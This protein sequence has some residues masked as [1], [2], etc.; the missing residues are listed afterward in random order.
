MHAQRTKRSFSK[1]QSLPETPSP[2]W[3]RPFHTNQGKDLDRKPAAR[4]DTNTRLNGAE[5]RGHHLGTFSILNQAPLAVQPRL[6]VRPAGDRYEQEA[7]RIAQQVLEMPAENAHQHNLGNGETL[8]MESTSQR[9]AAGGFE[10]SGN[11]ERLVNSRRGI[12]SPLS[13]DVRAK[14]EPHFGADFG[15][16][17][18]HTDS[19]SDKLVRSIQA[20][21]FA[22]GKDIFFSKGAYQPGSREG[23]ALIAH[24][25]THVTQQMGN[26]YIQ[27]QGNKKKKKKGGKEYTLL[28][29][30]VGEEEQTGREEESEDISAEISEYIAISK[31]F[32]R[33][34]SGEKYAAEISGEGEA[35]AE[36]KAKAII[37]NN[38]G[39]LTALAELGARIES[40]LHLAGEFESD[41][42]Q[43]KAEIKAAFKANV[44]AEAKLELTKEGIQ[45]SVGAEARVIASVDAQGSVKIGGVEL[46][47][48]AEAVAEASATAK[49]TLTVSKE[50]LE[51]SAEAGAFAG[52]S[53][54]ASAGVE[55][56]GLKYEVG[57]TAMAGIGGKVSG[58]FEIKGGKIRITGELA[59]ALGLGAGIDLDIE[60]DPKAIAQSIWQAIE[61]KVGDEIFRR[62]KNYITDRKARR[63]GY[64]RLVESYP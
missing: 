18:V 4:T 20:E 21:A 36:A 55:V 8:Q 10:V 13:A 45:V 62:I 2:F 51:V 3:H 56:K 28:E 60:I 50:G 9:F 5:G 19:Q 11:F 39:E 25:L 30:D 27:P 14:L 12:G 26:L 48:K 52:V 7:E 61:K 57:A 38:Q 47:G 64:T 53:A 49:G 1:D 54:H 46:K 40:R 31:R 34:M 32:A 15:D 41:Y 29:E 23:Q 44:G 63:E 33:E 17:H 6:T 22:I 37:E 24:E 43:A 16:V 35:E 59:L 58:S 42:L